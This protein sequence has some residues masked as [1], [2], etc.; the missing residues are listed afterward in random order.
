[1]R[2]LPFDPARAVRVLSRRDRDLGAWMRRFGPMTLALPARRS[3][4]ATLARSIVYQQ[5]TGVA[6]A[7]I[8]RRLLGV[9]PGRRRLQARDVDAVDD[10][11]LRAAGL[12]RP[13]VRALRD[14]TARTLGGE[15]PTRR[16]LDDLDDEAIVDALT[17][18]RGIGRWSVEMLL[19]FEL[20]RPD[21]LPAGDLGV[22]KGWARL[23]DAPRPSPAELTAR[24]EAW[25]PFRTVASW[26]L[27]RRLDPGD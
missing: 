9:F 2:T 14:L 4:Y 24:G 7:A 23:Y 8:H 6:A 17:T 18:V 25:R 10:A 1:M 15:L 21:V 19:I 20:G 26:Y 13:K 27:W 5:L 16:A 22:Q 11:T 3:V 12:S